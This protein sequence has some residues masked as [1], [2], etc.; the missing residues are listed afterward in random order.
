MNARWVPGAHEGSNRAA[1]E[2]DGRRPDAQRW[3]ELART[4]DR[5]EVA[6][7]DGMPEVVV[8]DNASTD[9]TARFLRGRDRLPTRVARQVELPQCHLADTSG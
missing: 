1:E 4:L 9:G 8:V 5:L 2:A 7:A 6:R 3:A